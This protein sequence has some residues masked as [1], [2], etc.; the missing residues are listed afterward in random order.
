MSHVTT[1]SLRLRN[2]DDLRAAAEQLGME[3]GEGV[4]HFRCY[5]G[6]KPCAHV[7]RVKGEAQDAWQIGLVAAADGDGYALQWD[8]WGP[9]GRR[10]VEAAGADMN[11]LRQEYAAANALRT[12]RKK[13]AGQGF[14]PAGRE[15]TADGRILLRLRRR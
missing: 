13:L 2:L 12:A 6:M 8:T 14:V 3:L 7:L 10:L 5:E 15:V 4:T 11:R 9:H 1:V